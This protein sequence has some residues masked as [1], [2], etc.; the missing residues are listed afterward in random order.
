MRDAGFSACIAVVTCDLSNAGFLASCAVATAGEFV[1]LG[2]L[3]VV[4]NAVL[5]VPGAKGG[6]GK[7]AIPTPARSVAAAAAAADAYFRGSPTGFD[8][9]GAGFMAEAIVMALA[10]GSV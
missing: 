4:G 7:G 3:L 6:G 10:V 2:E 8:G 9:G 5:T 1:A